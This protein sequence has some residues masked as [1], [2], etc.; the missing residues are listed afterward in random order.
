[1]GKRK[2]PQNQPATHELVSTISMDR[3]LGTEALGG[4]SEI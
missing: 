2:K 4:G 1:M 3:I